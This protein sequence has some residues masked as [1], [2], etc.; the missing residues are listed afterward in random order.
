M[1]D[2]QTIF[3]PGALEEVEGR[4]IQYGGKCEKCGKTSFPLPERCP[5]CGSSSLVKSPLSG[6]GTVFSYSITRVPV[7]PYAPPI[8]GAYIDLP[9]GVRL[10][11]QIYTKEEKVK[12]GMSVIVNTGVIWTEDDGTEILGYWYEPAQEDGGVR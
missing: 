4:L 6:K 3:H 7:G 9:E 10:F 12:T 11:A 8:I 1:K 5:F 2:N